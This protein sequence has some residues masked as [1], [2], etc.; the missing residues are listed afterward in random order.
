MD[1]FIA[2]KRLLSLLG[3]GK[4]EYNL[5]QTNHCNCLEIDISPG[6]SSIL[7]MDVNLEEE[8]KS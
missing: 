3:F 7:E 5:R 2:H 6:R 8:L 4:L 1:H